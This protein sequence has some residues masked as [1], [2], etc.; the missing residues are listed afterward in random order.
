VASVGLIISQTLPFVSNDTIKTFRH[1]VALDEHRTRF[2]VTLWKPESEVTDMGK[3]SGSN[4]HTNSSVEEMW[5]SG[6]HGGKFH[7]RMHHQFLIMI[8]D[9]GGG[10][11]VNDAPRNLSNIPFRWMLHEIVKAKCGILFDDKGLDYLKVPYDCVP[12][13]GISSLAMRLR[14]S[15]EATAI[16]DGE[17]SK[18]KGV[19]D[20]ILTWKEADRL[21]AAAESHDMLKREPIWWL[22]QFP[23]W[24]GRRIDWTGQRRFP[25]D[26]VHEERSNIHWTVTERMKDLKGYK[27]N[28][29]LPQDWQT[30]VSDEA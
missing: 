1:A 3:P 8:L 17:P 5:F 19:D 24:T 12:R 14:I 9:I 28:A 4:V 16:G 23:G 13:G 26:E 15:S 7:P 25:R 27:P 22:L 29:S 21:D 2:G 30:F 18:G 6:A 11:V 10:D 20:T